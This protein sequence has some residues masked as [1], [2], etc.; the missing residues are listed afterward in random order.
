MGLAATVMQQLCM[1]QLPIL[2]PLMKIKHTLYILYTLSVCRINFPVPFNFHV[3]FVTYR[4]AIMLKCWQASPDE[5]PPFSTL[6]VLVSTDL[7]RQAGYLEFSCSA[8]GFIAID[9]KEKYL[10]V[11]SPTLPPPP[12]IMV[13][14]PECD[15]ETP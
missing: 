5:R 7:E 15:V 3:F 12:M 1:A 6:V 10:A 11:P 13:T 9:S 2:A 14:Q 4:Y 8:D